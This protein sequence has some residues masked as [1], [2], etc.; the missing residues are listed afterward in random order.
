MARG[1][2]LECRLE[3]MENIKVPLIGANLR[4]TVREVYGRA[5]S[6]IR[7][8]VSDLFMA[9]DREKQ[10][11]VLPQNNIHASA[12]NPTRAPCKGSN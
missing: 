3:G 1:L 5:D 7:L 6:R 11:L 4:A 8:D 10:P 12:M 9:S 2:K